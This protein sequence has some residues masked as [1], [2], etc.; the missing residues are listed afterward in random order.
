MEEIFKA[1]ASWKAI[2][3]RSIYL[4]GAAG[5]I[6]SYITMFLIY[7]NEVKGFNISIYA[8]VRKRNKARQRF[9][10]Y[11]DKEYFHLVVGNVIDPI[12]RNMHV[13]YIV[14]AAS[15]ASPQ[16]YGEMPVEVM[17]PNIVGTYRLL[18][19]AR[20]T[21]VEGLLFLSSGEV[22]GSIEGT[23]IIDEETIGRMDFLSSG[24]T[25]GVGKQ[26]GEA[27]CK[28]YSR[29]Y[30]VPAKSA[31]I[32]HSYGPTMDVDSDERV[33]S[34]FVRSIL[35]DGD[36]VLKS[37]GTSKR[38][39][40][41]MTDVVSG[42]FAILLDGAS[43]ESYNLGNAN[44]Y[45]AIKELAE[46]LVSLFPERHLTVLYEEQDAGSCAMRPE[47]CASSFSTDKLEKLHWAACVTAEEGFARCVK[48]LGDD[49]L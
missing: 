26:C 35:R 43:G 18:E 13:S 8:G 5:M 6:A 28:A 40:C 25:Y 4:T 32:H 46:L 45:L 47:Q 21:A 36:I 41:Y 3:N 48:A 19:H 22:Y 31:R 23:G 17:L 2:D 11:I 12:D 42:L 29:E 39:F 30:A 38:A 15:L 9:G 44:E 7:L 24:N 10:D 16:Y 1:R 34:D 14:H 27:L 37:D 33:F 20:K 49:G